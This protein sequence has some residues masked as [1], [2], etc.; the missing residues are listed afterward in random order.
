MAR[1]AA[2]YPGQALPAE[3]ATEW[4]GP[5]AQFP[6]AEVWDAVDRHR[7]DMTEGRD[8]RPRGAWMPN[9]AELLAAVDKNWREQSAARREIEARQARA[10]RNAQ[11][12]VPMP[13]ETKEAMRI[14]A[15]ASTPPGHPDHVPG[16]IARKR[17]EMLADQLAER[18]DLAKRGE[19][20]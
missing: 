9:L 5:L 1:L 8:G 13:P 18:V 10:A 16:D 6:A 2:N 12:G 20:A 17:I 7:R 11:G 14:L 3:T 15:A 4:F 19:L